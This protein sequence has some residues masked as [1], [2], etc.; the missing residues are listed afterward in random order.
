MS[1]TYL[2]PE[3]WNKHWKL[4]GVTGALSIVW[5]HPGPHGRRCF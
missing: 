5:E 3:A 4:D 1:V 2:P